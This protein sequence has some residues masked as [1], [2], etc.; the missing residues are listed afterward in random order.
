MFLHLIALTSSDSRG[1]L[2]DQV[3]S[4]GWLVCLSAFTVPPG[5]WYHKLC[6]AERGA[7]LQEIYR[8]PHA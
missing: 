5:M 7:R 6:L 3:N 2:D 4:G 8:Y 1:K